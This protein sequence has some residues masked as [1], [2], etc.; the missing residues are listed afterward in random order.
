MSNSFKARLIGGLYGWSLVALFFIVFLPEGPFF[1]PISF[2]GA[3]IGIILGTIIYNVFINRP[4]TLSHSVKRFRALGFFL[5]KENISD[6]KLA[7]IINGE[8][9]ALFGED[10]DPHGPF[11]DLLL[12]SYDKKRVWWEDTEADVLNGNNV[13]IDFINDLS[14]ISKGEFSPS[15]ITETWETD[16]GPVYVQFLLDGERISINPKYIYDYIDVEIISDINKLLPSDKAKFEMYKPFDQT[17]FILML[18]KNKKSHLQKKRGW[19]FYPF[20]LMENQK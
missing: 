3:I 4:K 1:L 19:V 14:R 15:E 20:E 8:H 17:A 7:E 5:D 13:Y 11:S 10:I 6:E 9:L 18:S 2:L 12:L 16:E